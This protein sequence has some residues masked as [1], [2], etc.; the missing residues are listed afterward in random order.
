VPSA[1]EVARAVFTTLAANGMRDGVH[2]RLTLTRV[3]EPAAIPRKKWLSAV[4]KPHERGL[5]YE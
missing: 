4:L 1:D 2:M 3:W 5:D